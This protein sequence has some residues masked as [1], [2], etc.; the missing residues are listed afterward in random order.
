[1]QSIREIARKVPCE[2]EALLQQ[3]RVQVRHGMLE[4][5]CLWTAEIRAD[6]ERDSERQCEELSRELDL[7]LKLHAPRN[8]RIERGVRDTRAAELGHHQLC[9]DE[10]AAGVERVLEQLRES[11][12]ELQQSHFQRF[13]ALDNALATRLT[14]AETSVTVEEGL[15]RLKREAEAQV[16]ETNEACRLAFVQFRR[17]VA[18]HIG[19]VTV[20]TGKFQA[21]IKTFSEG[22]NYSA[23]EAQRA[24]AQLSG[25]EQRYE[26]FEGDLMGELAIIEN[27]ALSDTQERLADFD[28]HLMTHKSRL[29]LEAAKRRVVG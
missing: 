3:L 9:I 26:E 28:M 21:S 23:D 5:M 14:L 25:I 17:V 16:E 12:Q 15:G 10:H 4:H 13:G 29:R 1:M 8:E 24:L 2:R 27:N 6:A 19:R 18:E 22:G 7:R 11:F 20:S